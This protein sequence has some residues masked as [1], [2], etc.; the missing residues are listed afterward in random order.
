MNTVP[1]AF[2]SPIS[3]CRNGLLLMVLGCLLLCSSCIVQSPR[4]A[5][6]SQV[7]SLEVGMT[8]TEVEDVLGVGPYD[9]KSQDDSL[10]TLI[11]VYR[12]DDRRTLSL[13]TK[14][15]NGKSSKG[16]Y[17]QLNITYTRDGRVLRFDSCGMC[18]DNMVVTTAIDFE[19]TLGFLMVTVPSL[20]LL[21][22]LQ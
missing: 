2:L 16:K 5:T 18:P 8:K 9:L 12:V 19:K 14:A 13:L 6:I 3:V 22:G 20:L 17:V 10:R 1:L 21:V 7:L 4:Y 15:R 11:Y